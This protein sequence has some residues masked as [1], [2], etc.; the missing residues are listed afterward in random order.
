MRDEGQENCPTFT[1]IRNLSTQVIAAAEAK[2]TSGVTNVIRDKFVDR[3]I[4]FEH[5]K[6]NYLEALLKYD[7]SNIQNSQTQW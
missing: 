7:P 5:G 6:Y 1:V 2:A 4:L 3:V